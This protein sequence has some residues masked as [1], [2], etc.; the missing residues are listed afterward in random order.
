MAIESAR[1]TA[2]GE[3]AAPAKSRG[4]LRHDE[5]PHL[6]LS[7]RRLEQRERTEDE[8]DHEDDDAEERPE[9][10]TRARRQN[11]FPMLKWNARCEKKLLFFSGT[12]VTGQSGIVC[13]AVALRV[14]GSVVAGLTQMARPGT[15]AT[16]FCTENAGPASNA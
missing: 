8:A 15:P 12:Y 1:E 13:D 4:D 16:A 14:S 10:H 5:V 11:A 6:L 3:T 9:H 7:P 2:Q